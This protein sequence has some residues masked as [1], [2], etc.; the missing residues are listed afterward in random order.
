VKSRVVVSRGRGGPEVLE[1]IE[2][3]L[4]APGP[5]QVRVAVEAAGVAFGDVM[6]RRGVLAPRRAFTPGY[7][8]VGVVDQA[9]AGVDAIPGRRVAVLM[10]KPGS[11]GYAEHV[12]V[13]ADR[14]VAVPD[15]VDADVAVALGLNY[16][17]AYQLIHRFV[18][19]RPG[20]RIL[21]HGA[22]G[23]VGS[24]LLDVGR[25]AGLEMFGTASSGKHDLVRR[26]GATPI[27]YRSEDFVA[28][29]AELAGGGVDA[30]FDGIGGGHLRR[31]FRVLGRRGTLVSFGVS[32]ARGLGGLLAEAGVFVAL[33]LRPDRKR[34]RLYLI[35]VSRGASWRHCRDDWGALLALYQQGRLEP[36]IGARVPLGEVRRA[37]QLIDDAAVAGKI[38]LTCAPS[39]AHQ[40]V[41]S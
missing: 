40:A 33:K 4:P 34:V 3:E 29:M 18:G 19:L 23:G 10:P 8:V 25:A 11:G 5:G 7:D 6:R 1:V 16:V 36:V 41:A 31:S 20:Q 28:R 39:A 22:A 14:L 35:T 13:P 32:G 17:T 30:V 9:G 27:D 37:H 26:F 38:V 2:R 15:G 24:A 12:V 21:V